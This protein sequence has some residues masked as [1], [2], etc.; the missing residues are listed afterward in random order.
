MESCH[1]IYVA[2]GLVPVVGVMAYFKEYNT[3]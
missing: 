3:I 1:T 2:Q